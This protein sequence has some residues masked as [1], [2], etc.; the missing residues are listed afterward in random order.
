MSSYDLSTFDFTPLNTYWGHVGL[1]LLSI[2]CISL[3]YFVTATRIGAKRRVFFSRDF[4]SK[5]DDIH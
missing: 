1:A 4:M 5:F 2:T 3:E